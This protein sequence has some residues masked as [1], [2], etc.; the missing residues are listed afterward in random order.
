M[1]SLIHVT[2]IGDNVLRSASELTSVTL[3]PNVDSI[4]IGRHCLDD[5][6]KLS[7]EVRMS[8]PLMRAKRWRD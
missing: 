1:E 3:P 2:S 4:N 7:S 8:L 6:G 5:C